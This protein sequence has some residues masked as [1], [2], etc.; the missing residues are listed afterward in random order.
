[1]ITSA[2]IHNLDGN[3]QLAVTRASSTMMQINGNHIVMVGAATLAL[4]LLLPCSNISRRQQLNNGGDS[5]TSG[6]HHKQ[7]DAA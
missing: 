6:Q 3:N 1:M 4:Q 5:N 7:M 2:Q